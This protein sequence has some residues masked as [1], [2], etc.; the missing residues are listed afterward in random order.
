MFYKNFLRLLFLF[1]LNF[2][3][4]IL[5]KIKWDSRDLADFIIMNTNS[6]IYSYDRMYEEKEQEFLYRIYDIIDDYDL[7][8]YIYYIESI[9]EYLYIFKDN[10]KYYLNNYLGRFFNK[11]AFIIMINDISK[12]IIIMGD[13]Y[14]NEFTNNESNN[15]KDLENYISIELSNNENSIEEIFDYSI[16]QLEN[17]LEGKEIEPGNSLIVIII[18]VIIVIIAIVIIAIYN[19]CCKRNKIVSIGYKTYDPL[20]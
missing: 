13:E 10:L 6:Y 20:K 3:F 15:I 16:K 19:I 9:D 5:S 18:I 4:S 7:Y 1:F 12:A 2:K 11:C 8:T 14:F 17:A